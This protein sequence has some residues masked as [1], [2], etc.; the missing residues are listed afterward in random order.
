LR[1]ASGSERNK[2]KDP[3]RKAIRI[4]GLKLMDLSSF[5]SKGIAGSVKCACYLPWQQSSPQPSGQQDFAQP[6][7]QQALAQLSVQ[8]AP[9]LD[10]SDL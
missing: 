3:D 9:Q 2:K 8:H 6:S 7:E 10:L 1:R 5:D 4:V